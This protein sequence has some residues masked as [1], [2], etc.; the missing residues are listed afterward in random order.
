MK[1]NYTL[2][3]TNPQN[4]MAK[5]KIDAIKPTGVSS[6]K[7]FL[8]SWSPGSYLM[9][10]YTTHVRSVRVLNKTGEFL[11][12][13]Q[14]EKGIWEIDW[15]RS[16][17]KSES[18][19]FSFEYE[20]YCHELTVR[21]NH[22]DESHAFL[23]GP[24]LFMGVL[25]H[26]MPD[27][28]LRVKFPPLWSKLHTGMTDISEKR[29]KF[30]Y[31]AKNYD[32]FIDCPIEIGCHDSDGFM[33]DGKEHHVIFY[34]DQYPHQ[35]DLKK[36]IKTIV[37]TTA[38]HFSDLP[39][40]SYLF[41]THFV[42]NKFGGLEHKNSTALQFDG[43]RLSN[44]KDYINWLALVAHEY[45]HTW[46]VK[47]IRP[48]ELG[49]FDYTTENYT[50]LHWLTEGLTSFMDELLVLRAGLCTL[51]EYLV[52]QKQNLEKYFAIPGKKFHSLEDASFNAW[53]KLYRPDENTTNSSVSYYL[54]GGLV[55]ST[56]HF[57][58]VKVGSSINELLTKLWDR[59][60]ADEDK[61]VNRE[62]V[63]D[64]IEEV[65]NKEIR[66]RFEQKISTTEDIDFE[67]LYEEQGMKFIWVETQ[68]PYIG[69]DWRFDGEN[70]YLAKVIL[71]QPGC[72]AGLNAG[73]EVIA[74]NGL[75]FSKTEAMNLENFLVPGTV[76]KFTISRLEK[77]FEINVSVEK[78]PRRLKQIEIF[79]KDKANHC[80]GI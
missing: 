67:T 26:E 49:P 8:P 47:R 64:M 66:N 36:D 28:V 43:R 2:E 6:L 75:R 16:D 20:I 62:E 37:E 9:R 52:M 7:F 69:V 63:L 53:V 22:I 27:P 72:K 58:L 56:L 48:V 29:D 70:A 61:G 50:R 30:I 21:T 23:H 39:Y 71:D 32:D 74:I 76:Y 73:D 51:E 65:G 77:L 55:F 19:E 13:E 10:E 59:Y 57:D 12:F 40:E 3:I 41:M 44:R 1:L 11:Y 46:N 60:K 78:E 45:F 42:K 80:F 17:C 34:G 18:E 14:L 25:D 24:A 31:T 4:H 68:K 15:S 38:E 79:D 33:H 5:I 35:Y 54:K